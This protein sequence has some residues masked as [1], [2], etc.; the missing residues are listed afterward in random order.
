M[1][2][3]VLE[4]FCLGQDCGSFELRIKALNFLFHNF[5]QKKFEFLFSIP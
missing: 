2:K 3:K 5:L 4:A 1:Q